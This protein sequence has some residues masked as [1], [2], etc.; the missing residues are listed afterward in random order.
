MI[1][2]FNALLAELALAG[3]GNHCYDQAETIARWLDETQ[4]CHEVAM[5]IR[6]FSLMNQGQYQEAMALPQVEKWPSLGP[7][8]AF[9]EWRLGRGCAFDARIQALRASEHP[10]FRH[11]ADAMDSPEI[12]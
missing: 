6:L 7:L 4:G 10:L 11:F 5:M 2:N 12:L 1:K 3:T 9:C 8:L